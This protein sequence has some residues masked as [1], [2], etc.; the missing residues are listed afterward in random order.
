MTRIGQTV[1][2]SMF[3]AL[4]LVV[5]ACGGSSESS[6]CATA[7]HWQK[8]LSTIPESASARNVVRLT[9]D[10]LADLQR[11][12]PDEIKSDINLTMSK[13]N[14]AVDEDTPA[15]EIAPKMSRLT[16]D[17]AFVAAGKRIDAYNSKACG[18]ERS[19]S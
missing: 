10:E 4:I 19:S 12:A 8:T 13:F 3:S 16:S 5:T 15:G 14:S 6:Y 2:V 18:I 9:K 1:S 17:P 11:A 7:K